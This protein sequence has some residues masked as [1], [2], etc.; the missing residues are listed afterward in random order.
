[1]DAVIDALELEEIQ[2]KRFRYKSAFVF[3]DF[4]V[5]LLL[6]QRDEAGYYS[7]FDGGT[8][9][10]WPKDVVADDRPVP[11]TSP[12]AVQA[13]RKDHA[14]PPSTPDELP[15][16]LKADSGLAHAVNDGDIA[17]PIAEGAAQFPTRTLQ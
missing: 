7:Q 14:T 17:R 15:G 3:N 11:I 8:R 12:T 10:D 6:V 16:S 13:F 4:M 1:M 2:A 5:E 9:Y